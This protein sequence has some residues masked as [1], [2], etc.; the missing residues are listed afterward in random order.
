MNRI[1]PP[2]RSSPSPLR[3]ASSFVVLALAVAIV[4]CG[5]RTDSD[6]GKDDLRVIRDA[7]AD[8]RS[9]IMVTARGEVVRIL[10][11]DLDGSR[12]Q[13]FIVSLDTD[14]TVLLSHNIDLAPRVPVQIGDSV[15]FRGQYEWNDRGGVVHWTHRDPSGRREGGWIRYGE[16]QFK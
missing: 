7:F 5:G 4:G 16:R 10:S 15:A 6:V 11:D 14:H 1:T 9:G 3:A 8:Q 13:R 12:H 2:R